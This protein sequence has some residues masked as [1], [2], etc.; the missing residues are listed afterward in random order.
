MQSLLSKKVTVITGCNKG[1]GKSILIKFAEQG[2][3]IFACT[4]QEDKAF[5]DFCSDISKKYQTKIHNIFLT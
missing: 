3:I 2:S 4:R 1:I 5:S